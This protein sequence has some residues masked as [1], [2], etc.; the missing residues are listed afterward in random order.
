MDF[1]YGCNTSWEITWPT[2]ISS[3]AIARNSQTPLLNLTYVAAGP[4]T[5]MVLYEIAASQTA[6]VASGSNIEF[7]GVGKAITLDHMT[8][9]EP[10]FASQVAHAAAGMTRKQAGEVFTQLYDLYSDKLPNPPKGTRFQDC[11]DWGSITPCEEYVELVSRVT[12]ELKSYGLEL[13]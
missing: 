12:E 2:C 5:D 6:R 9:T 3:S 7:G 10:R 8:P 1:R 11:Y 13:V 4:M